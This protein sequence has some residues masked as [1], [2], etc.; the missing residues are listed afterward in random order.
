MQDLACLCLKS[1]VCFE[2]FWGR[3]IYLWWSRYSHQ[4]KV[5]TEKKTLAEIMARKTPRDNDDDDDALLQ[6]HLDTHHGNPYFW[7]VMVKFLVKNISN[8]GLNTPNHVIFVV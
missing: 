4:P 8:S 3:R 7:T 1:T 6:P 2:L 5:L